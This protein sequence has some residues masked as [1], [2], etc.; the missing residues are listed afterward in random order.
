MSSYYGRG[1]QSVNPAVRIWP[2][3]TCDRAGGCESCGHFDCN[4]ILALVPTILI[5][6]CIVF[7]YWFCFFCLGRVERAARKKCLKCIKDS[8]RRKKVIFGYNDVG[9][10]VI[11]DLCK[12]EYPLTEVFEHCDDCGISICTTSCRAKYVGKGCKRKGHPR[13]LTTGNHKGFM[14][15]GKL[16]ESFPCDWCGKTCK[17]NELVEHCDICETNY[18]KKCCR[19]RPKV[20]K[21]CADKLEACMG[22]GGKMFLSYNNARRFQRRLREL[23]G[24]YE[25]P[26]EEEKKFHFYL[27]HKHH[28]STLGKQPIQFAEFLQK[29]LEELGYKGKVSH[30]HDMGPYYAKSS[31]LVIACLNNETIQSKTC[32]LEWLTADHEEIPMVAIFDQDNFQEEELKA[33]FKEDPRQGSR[34]IREKP[35]F[36]C[37][38]AGKHELVKTMASWIE[39][40]MSGDGDAFR[41]E[42]NEGLRSK[43]VIA[44]DEEEREKL[45]A[46]ERRQAAAA[47]LSTAAE[48][49]LTIVKSSLWDSGY[50]GVRYDEDCCKYEARRLDEILGHFDTAEEA[51]LEFARDLGKMTSASLASVENAVTNRLR[52]PPLWMGNRA[53]VSAKETKDDQ[54]EDDD[55][56]EEDERK[57][58]RHLHPAAPRLNTP[59]SLS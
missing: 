23:R 15:S 17:M 10:T 45:I 50:R 5:L 26:L 2:E 52:N 27:S 40:L 16:V 59:G 55:E 28:H 47:A 22:E 42:M 14:E 8:H 20:W 21:G 46:E 51:A 31:S 44:R 38:A 29:S 41:A 56:E 30:T 49:G 9:P 58:R 19:V 25:K 11:C 34:L 48:E 32:Q 7:L 6:S 35:W 39:K 18:C 53:P 12:H 24:Y 57:V 13:Y 1:L 36:A 3:E 43:S 33:G 54:D 37:N 4:L